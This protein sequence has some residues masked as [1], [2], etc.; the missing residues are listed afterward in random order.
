M[1]NQRSHFLKLI[2]FVLMFILVFT[3]VPTVNADTFTDVPNN[4]WAKSAILEMKEKGI[5]NGLPDGS[6]NPN[7]NISRAEF[8]KII[9]LAFNLPT[10]DNFNVSSLFKDI[11]DNAWYKEY[12]NAASPYLTY[13][14][15][16]DGMYYKPTDKGVRE[17]IAVALVVASGISDMPLNNPNL[18]KET[19]Y[20]A[21]DISPKLRH[22]VALAVENGLITG[23]PN[24]TFQPQEPINRASAAILLSRTLKVKQQLVADGTIKLSN[25]LIIP[26][27]E[28]L[29][30]AETT[31]SKFDIV[32]KTQKGNIVYINGI[33]AYVD[34][35]GSF[36]LNVQLKPGE[37]TIVAEAYNKSGQK[38]K[39]ETIISLKYADAPVISVQ[40]P[41]EVNKEN[42]EFVINVDDPNCTVFVDGYKIERDYYGNYNAKFRNLK[43]GDNAFEIKAVNKQ[44]VE[45]IKKITIKF[46]KPTPDFTISA[47][48]TVYEN[49]VTIQ[50]RLGAF[51]DDIYI[52]GKNVTSIFR[53]Y[54]NSTTTKNKYEYTLKDQLKEGENIIEMKAVSTEGVPTTKQAKVNYVIAGP[55][56]IVTV[57]DTVTQNYVE[58]KGNVKDNDGMI[59]VYVNEKS[60]YVNWNK[61]FSET[62]SN[63]K[64]GQNTIT[65][66]A[67]NT[68]GKETIKKVTVEYKI[69][70]PE[71]QVTIPDVTNDKEF[72]ISGKT[73]NSNNK[74]YVNGS[75]VSNIDYNGNF[76]FTVRLRDDQEGMNEIKVYASNAAGKET[77]IKKMVK[78]ERLG[79]DV[80]IIAPEDTKN[81]NAQITIITDRDNIVYID[82]NKVNSS[83]YSKEREYTVQLAPGN[84][85]FKVEAI[86]TYGKKTTKNVTIKL[87][88]EGIKLTA[89]TSSDKV[90][91]GRVTISGNTNFGNKLYINDIYVTYDEKGN[92]QYDLENLSEGQNTIMVK[93]LNEA[94]NENATKT[95]YVIYEIPKPEININIPSTTGNSQLQING[96]VKN[97]D[98]VMINGETISISNGFFQK[99]IDLQTGENNIIIEAEN[100]YGKVLRKEYTINYYPEMTF[101]L[102]TI[103]PSKVTQDTFVLSGTAN[104]IKEII[105]KVNGSQVSIITQDGDFSTDVGS[106]LANNSINQITFEIKDL[107]DN[108]TTKSEMVYKESVVQGEITQEQITEEESIE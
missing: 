57:P 58:V 69:G 60:T 78:F 103:I 84:N 104:N 99:N 45:A 95:L 70:A 20:D 85:V 94:T 100:N 11:P 28:I 101:N 7:G 61:E 17:D 67:T 32:G 65:V 15:Y 31:K 44:G 18:L 49:K 23:M 9:T 62:V 102:N 39:K 2:G 64:E 12:I 105:I 92:F 71:L 42:V 77:T 86:N 59:S 16:P 1:K 97:G 48:D 47:P 10:V 6:F 21:E 55:K 107:L 24:G 41:N 27:I 63:L 25:D 72:V 36:S 50:G 38:C 87:I 8:S 88:S 91:E 33:L 82:G 29:V 5:I 54:L 35:D 83:Y 56:L 90:N 93:A 37:N 75:K 96:S 73:D 81:K 3:N 108:M 51:C 66:K 98:M 22:T 76:T 19:F 13:W 68:Q 43:E 34:Y 52:N 106:Y 79:P 14:D 74:V 4:H 26:T 30:P 80:Q 89:S 46:T 53:T 40:A